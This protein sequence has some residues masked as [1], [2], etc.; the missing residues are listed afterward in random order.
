MTYD[1]PSLFKTP[2]TGTRT[3]GGDRLLA[4]CCVGGTVLQ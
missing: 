1:L 3:E 2:A 4:A